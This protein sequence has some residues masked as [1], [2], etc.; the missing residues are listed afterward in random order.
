MDLQKAAKE[1]ILFLTTVSY[2]KILCIGTSKDNKILQDKVF[3]LCNQLSINT[4]FDC[5]QNGLF[6]K[7][8]YDWFCKF[9]PLSVQANKNENIELL[10][11]YTAE[12]VL[13]V[14]NCLPPQLNYM[15]DM[16]KMY[17]TNNNKTELIRIWT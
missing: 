6:M 4:E 14:A 7:N 9:I 8:K 13:I 5:K 16:I 12:N 2:P 3:T 1:I 10:S 11:G 15:Y 17:L